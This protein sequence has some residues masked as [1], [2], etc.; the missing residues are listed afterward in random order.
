MSDESTRF[1]TTFFSSGGCVI[2]SRSRA[3]TRRKTW[4]KKQVAAKPRPVSVLEVTA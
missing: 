2:A 1:D 3:T 4:A